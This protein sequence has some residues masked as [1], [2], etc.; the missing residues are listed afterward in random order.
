MISGTF[1]TDPNDRVY[2]LKSSLNQRADPGNA[3]ARH[4]IIYFPAKELS[5]YCGHSKYVQ[6]YG[7]MSDYLTCQGKSVP[8]RKCVPPVASVE[9][10]LLTE[11]KAVL[12]LR[13]AASAAVFQIDLSCNSSSQNDGYIRF[14]FRWDCS[15]IQVSRQCADFV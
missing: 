1:A 4:G 6:F 13:T 5:G 8:M 10:S 12:Q 7:E 11:S 2:A 14:P 9:I 15:S 3:L